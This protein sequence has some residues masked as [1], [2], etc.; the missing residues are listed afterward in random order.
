MVKKLFRKQ[1]NEPQAGVS[2]LLAILVLSAILSISFSLASV[3]L[4]EI[5]SSGDLLRTEPSLYAA[6]AITEESI[7]K[8]KRKTG[9]S[10]AAST[11]GT[12]S[13]SAPAESTTSTPAQTV[14][15]LPGGSFTSTAAR[16]LIFD[17][18]N[19]S[20]G[21][22]DPPCGSG[23][24]R[25]KVTYLD[26]GNETDLRLYLCEFNPA[27]A[28]APCT[29]PSGSDFTYE[30]VAVTR[31]TSTAWVSPLFDFDEQQE[32]VLIN[33]SPSDM[34]VIIETFALDGVTGKGLPYFG[35]TAIEVEANNA[36]LTRTLR[37]R[38]PND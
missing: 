25:I 1:N 3:L 12:V 34:Y 30:N 14:K 4:I 19:P 18:A 10:I 29:S 16:Y 2:L 7:F 8:I 38:I 35:E 27:T 24:G 31:G 9:V 17:P 20:C 33:T 37:S 5:K 13:V 6:Q 26:S 32:L 21:P 15:I 11:I 36:G 23:Y 22:G 28:A